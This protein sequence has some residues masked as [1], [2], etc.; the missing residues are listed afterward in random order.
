MDFDCL[1]PS[2]PVEAQ[3]PLTFPL[4]HQ[5]TLNPFLPAHGPGMK[6]ITTLEPPTLPLAPGSL[7]HVTLTYASSLDSQISLSRG[8]QTV[9]SG[10]ET[11]AM[12]HYL[13]SRH[14][15]ILVGVGTA[16]TDDPGLNCR[17]SEDGMRVV[18]MDRQ[19]VP[20]ILDP[21][22]RWSCKWDSK[23]LTLA[24]EDK[25]NAPLW[26]FSDNETDRISNS[27]NSKGLIEQGGGIQPCVE[28][29]S[30]NG[31]NWRTVL[32][33]LAS[34]GIKSVMVEGG[35]KVIEDLLQ[36]KNQEFVSSVIV[37]IAPVWLGSGGV[38]VCPP[39]GSISREVG[40]LAGVK[41]IPMGEDVVMAGKFP[42]K[43]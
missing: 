24:R 41:W 16:E 38:T 37:T 17:F 8:V 26:I 6:R 23:V 3:K 18:G 19:P 15:A 34:E 9:L 33:G 31:V 10:A 14:D 1:P 43:I 12:T 29:R 5:L 7:P 32:R 13:R 21:S 25:G 22:G 2:A 11:K 30:G 42:G 40:R 27:R 4:E 36:E 20:V 35:A 28:L 39:R